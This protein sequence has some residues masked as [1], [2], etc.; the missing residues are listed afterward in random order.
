MSGGMVLPLEEMK[1]VYELAQSKQIPL[2][3]DGARIFNAANYLKVDVKEI[4]QYAD[5]VMFCL[6]KG[7]SA[8][9][10][11]MLV[12]TKEFIAKA[13][14]LRK[15]L[16][17]GMRQVG[18]IASA[19][20]VA[21]RDHGAWLDLDHQNA[22]KL[23]EGLNAIEGVTVETEKVHT[24]ILMADVSATGIKAPELVEKMKEKGLLVNPRNERLIRFVTHRGVNNHDVEAAINI[25]KEILA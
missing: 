7:M 17:G 21:L 9:I 12:G 18:I 15:M 25:V 20:I 24:N 8:P 1:K 10:G 2:H 16:G 3:I 5:S 13:R 22:R 19:G 23:A 11:S 6:S 4:A 14:K